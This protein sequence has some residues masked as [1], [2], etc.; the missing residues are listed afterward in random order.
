MQLQTTCFNE[1]RCFPQHAVFTVRNELQKQ[2]VL[3]D[4]YEMYGSNHEEAVSDREAYEQVNFC[5]LL[6]ELLKLAFKFDA[7]FT[8]LSGNISLYTSTIEILYPY[9]A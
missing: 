7:H 9:L 2:V 1:A 4:V 8:H 5:C 6:P 3:E